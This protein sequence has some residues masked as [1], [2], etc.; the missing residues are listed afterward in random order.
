M[1][2]NPTLNGYVV[3]HLLSNI[4]NSCKCLLKDIEDVRIKHVIR[5]CNIPHS[6]S[7]F[8]DDFCERFLGLDHLELCPLG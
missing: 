5:E 7:A 2:A 6:S 3:S 4:L 8:H 1:L